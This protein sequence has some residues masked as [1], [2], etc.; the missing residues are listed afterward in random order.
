MSDNDKPQNFYVNKDKTGWSISNTGDSEFG[1]RL[2]FKRS[3]VKSIKLSKKIT[4]NI[5][6]LKIDIEGFETQVIKEC[7]KKL[8]NVGEIYIE[9]HRYMNK[10]QNN[11]YSLINL[12]RKAKF[13]INIDGIAIN[14][15]KKVKF[16]VNS[17]KPLMIIRARR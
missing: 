9:Y 11:I 7:F 13:N 10:K 15:N 4:S 16:E 8:N 1:P 6:L 12:L 5:Q 14:S 17:K 3:I 2:N